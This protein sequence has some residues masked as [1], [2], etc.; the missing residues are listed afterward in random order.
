MAGTGRIGAE[1]LRKREAPPELQAVMDD[2][3]DTMALPWLPFPWAAYSRQGAVLDLFWKRLRDL[4]G[5]ELFLR[6]SLAIAGTV[7]MGISSWYRPAG[8]IRLAG[9]DMEPFSLSR[10]LDAFE[11][12]N[13]Q[14]LIQQMALSRMLRGETVGREGKTVPRARPGPFRW[15]GLEYPAWEDLPAETSALV[16]NVRHAWSLPHPVPDVLALAKWPAFLEHAWAELKAWRVRPEYRAMVREIA[17]MGEDALERLR[18]RTEIR[19]GELG[20]ALEKSGAWP[21][22]VDRLKD[23][24]LSFTMILPGLILDNALLRTAAAAWREP[25][26]EGGR[27]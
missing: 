16:R 11:F 24:V 26:P 17:D 12:G 27:P 5:N 7:H 25:V 21:S 3:Q 22:G 19:E 10:E 6:E 23:Q 14:L 13:P 15:P 9:L 8:G 18:P 1:S 20:A 4:T 2:I